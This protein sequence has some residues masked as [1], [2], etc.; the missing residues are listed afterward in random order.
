MDW[1]DTGLGPRGHIHGHIYLQDRTRIQSVSSSG[2]ERNASLNHPTSAQWD[3][4]DHM[5]SL[6]LYQARA[7]VSSRII[8]SYLSNGTPQHC[9]PFFLLDRTLQDLS[10][11]IRGGH[12]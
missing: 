12:R 9:Q 11:G 1:D 6:L 2:V 4:E 8:S 7:Y 10:P 5:E 3:I